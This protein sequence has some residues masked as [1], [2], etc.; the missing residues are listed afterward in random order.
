MVTVSLRVPEP[1]RSAQGYSVPK[2]R[3]KGVIDGKQ[4]NIPVPIVWSDAG[5]EEAKYAGRWLS[6]CKVVGRSLCK[7]RAILY[8]EL[9]RCAS[10]LKVSM[11][12]SQ[13]KPLNVEANRPYPK[14]TQVDKERILRRLSEAGPRNSAN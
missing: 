3:P 8:R 4:V 12:C 11:P 6:R 7:A 13:E 14:P 5:V 9:M 10:A 2:V 1:C